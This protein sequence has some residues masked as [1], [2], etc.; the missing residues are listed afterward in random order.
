MQATTE[1]DVAAIERLIT[2]KTRAIVVVHYGGLPCN[3]DELS[4]IEQTYG[5]PVIQDGAHAL[6]LR[7]RGRPIH[8][9]AA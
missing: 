5:I 9:T 4:R 7:W 3:L 8:S 6:G 2:E 1:D